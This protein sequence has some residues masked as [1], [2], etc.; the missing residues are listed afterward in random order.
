MSL[1]D[2]GFIA[3][4]NKRIPSYFMLR[5]PG[6]PEPS[7][8]QWRFF[9][10]LRFVELCAAEFKAERNWGRF[11]GISNRALWERVLKVRKPLRVGDRKLAC[12]VCSRVMPAM[13][14]GDFGLE[15]PCGHV[16]AK[17]CLDGWI[18]QWAPG[19]RFNVYP[20]CRGPMCRENSSLLSEI[21]QVHGIDGIDRLRK[22]ATKPLLPAGAWLWVL[23]D[24]WK[25]PIRV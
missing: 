21:E 23:Q 5:I 13:Y 12:S 3:M 4:L 17:E 16:V 8:E 11:R 14:H 25:E 24:A 18:S 22:L 20:V 1:L 15:M 9:E 6:Q 2:A 10:Q 7:K 19:N